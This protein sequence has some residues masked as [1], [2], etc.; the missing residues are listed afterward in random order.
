MSEEVLSTVPS[1]SPSPKDSTPPK[2]ECA[3][4]VFWKSEGFSLVSGTCHRFPPVPLNEHQCL[5]PVLKHDSS[6]GEFRYDSERASRMT[7]AIATGE[8]EELRLTKMARELYNAAQTGQLE[9]ERKQV[10]QVQGHTDNQIDT[11]KQVVPP[12]LNSQASQTTT[13]VPKH[14]PVLTVDRMRAL[15]AGRGGR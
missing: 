15:Q 8:D 7:Q 4:C 14:I 3:T 6:C 10:H 1:P 2:P 13:T 12:I 11:M 5:W 9:S